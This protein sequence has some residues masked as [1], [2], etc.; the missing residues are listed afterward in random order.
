MISGVGAGMDVRGRRGSG[1][2]DGTLWYS[3]GVEAQ[4]HVCVSKTIEC[5]LQRGEFY[6]M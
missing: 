2:G 3:G 1:G 4:M 6:C 5:M